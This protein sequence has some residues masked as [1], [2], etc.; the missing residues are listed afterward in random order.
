MRSLRSYWILAGLSLGIALAALWLGERFNT[1]LDITANQRHSLSEASREVLASLQ[2][3]VE[4]IAVLGPS[5]QERRAVD[6]M[7]ERYQALKP[8]LEWRY[9]NPETDP[10]EARAL[11]AAPGGELIIHHGEREQRLGSL[12]ER[13]LSDALARLT[14]AG[15]RRV[16]FIE[17]HG[18]RSPSGS[19]NDDWQLL[20]QH[21]ARLG[22]VS[23][24]QSLISEPLIDP[25]VALVVIADSRQPWLPGEVR[26]LENYLAAGGNLLWL[27]EPFL[28]GEPGNGLE[29]LAD[30]LGVD[31]LP[32]TVIDAASQ[33]QSD[34]VD[35]VILDRFPVHEI[36]RSLAQPMLLPQAQ[37]LAVTP[38]AGQD[39]R[40]L[41]KTPADS[42]SETGPLS[43]EISHD[44]ASGETAGPLLLG[45]TI[46]RELP[47]DREPRPT[48][49]FAVLGDADFASSRFLGNGS[50]RAFAENLFLWLTG[51]S[52]V[53]AFQAAAPPDASLSLDERDI[54]IISATALAGL[55][56]LVLLTGLVYRLWRR[57]ASARPTSSP[58]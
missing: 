1:R 24:Q 53:M 27:G 34:A 35:F 56:L 9:L 41:L 5:P 57:R 40:A 42:W 33:A 13:T 32:G 4:I 2:G 50:N 18:E 10:A 37:A 28:E 36:N 14:L 21:L 58:S 51:D 52:K 26:S 20:A 49:R 46:E 48:Q 22:L 17:G 16:V 44:A 29:R 15:E 43:G 55:P 39:E 30:N 8:D 47:G 23:E 19:L 7:L 31:S 54:V 12:S 45:L 38:L 11:E 3:P 25:E 6:A